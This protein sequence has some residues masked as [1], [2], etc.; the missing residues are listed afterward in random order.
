MKLKKDF[1]KEEILRVAKDEFLKKG[2]RDASLREIAKKTNRTT[3]VIYT[4]FRNKNEIFERL[5]QPVLVKFEHKLASKEISFDEAR[6]TEGNLKKWFTNYIRF[7]IDL[8]E[9]NRDE[10]KLLFLKSE[11]SSYTNL[12]E[13][14]IEIGITKR[15]KEFQKLTRTP[16]F[17]GQV[18][19][20]FFIR[21]LVNYVFNASIEMLKQNS[22]KAEID[23]YEAEITAFVH[24]GWKALVEI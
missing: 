14:L 18:L 1:V 23:K 6:A 8:V 11:G 16:E 20:E 9:E 15:K 2:F 7:L 21:N 22:S 17:K 10:M 24:S 3:G 4:Y 12:K 13:E 5:V 19:S